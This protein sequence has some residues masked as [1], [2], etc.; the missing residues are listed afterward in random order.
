MAIIKCQGCKPHEFQDKKYGPKRRVHNACKV[1]WRCTI[2]LSVKDLDAGSK[3]DEDA[4][5][6]VYRQG[7][8]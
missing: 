6:R 3:N 7:G 8:K 1:G 5:K 4:H 2:C